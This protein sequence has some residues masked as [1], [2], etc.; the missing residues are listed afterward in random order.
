VIDTDKIE[1]A[2]ISILEAIGEDVNREGIQ[3]TPKRVARWWSE[4]IDYDAGKIDTT[5]EGMSINQ[6]VIVKDIKVWSLC[7]HHL[8]PFWCNIS[9]GYISRE[10]VLGLSKFARIAN[11]H[12]HKLQIQ[13][14]LVDDIAKEIIELIDCKDVAVIGNGEHLCM[15]MRG[16]KTPHSM[17]SSSI[18]GVFMDDYKTRS[19]F[20]NLI[21]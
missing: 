18:N 15:S 3:D 17:I 6:M 9:I 4:F 2:Y 11:K 20:L 7:E 21:K 1:R 19:E 13:E 10:K 14:K 16:I 5:F 12:A 8:L